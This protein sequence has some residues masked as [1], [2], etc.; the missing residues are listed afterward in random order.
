VINYCD[1]AV[2]RDC[3]MT[4]VPLMRNKAVMENY[5][6]LHVETLLGVPQVRRGEPGFE[7]GWVDPN[8]RRR[9]ASN[10]RWID[11]YG[12]VTARDCRFGGED[13]GFAAVWN[14]AHYSYEY[15]VV[16]NSVTLEDCSAYNAQSTLVVLKEVPNVLKV[17]NCQGL[18]DC[19]IVRVAPGLDL[20]TYFDPKGQPFPVVIDIRGNY[21]AQGSG[22]PEQMLPYQLGEIVSTAQPRKGNWQRGQFVRNLNAGQRWDETRQM[23]VPVVTAALDEPYGWF[24]TESGKP[25]KWAPVKFTVPPQN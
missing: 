17:V 22:L 20:D 7:D 2:V 10:Q 24:C 13:G 11:N 9:M 15:P 23:T 1:K 19:W 4:T 8:G 5:G 25:G 18:N 6:V 3:W 21:E 14:F 12:T 16:P